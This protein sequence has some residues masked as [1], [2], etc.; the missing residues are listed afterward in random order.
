MSVIKT[1]N[2]SKQTTV[3]RSLLSYYIY[4]GADEDG[5]D[6]CQENVSGCGVKNLKEKEREGDVFQV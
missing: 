5:N 4:C 1:N 6:K 3:A 2:S